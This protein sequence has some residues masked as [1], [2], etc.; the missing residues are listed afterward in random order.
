VSKEELAIRYLPQSY[1]LV[2]VRIK[3]SC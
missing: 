2:Y 1:I 3:A